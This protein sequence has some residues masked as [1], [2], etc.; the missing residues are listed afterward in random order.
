MNVLDRLIKF[1]KKHHKAFEPFSDE[2]IVVF[3]I[4]YKQTTK[5]RFDEV[6][7]ITGFAVWEDQLDKVVFIAIAGVGDRN[8]NYREIMMHL[9]QF[10]KPVWIPYEK[11]NK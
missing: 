7:N 8:E 6:G 10:G 5:V 2:Q 4:K 1:A 3:F 11:G 9:R